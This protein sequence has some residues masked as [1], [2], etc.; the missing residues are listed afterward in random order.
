MKWLVVVVFGTLNYDFYVF[1][2]PKHDTK[3]ICMET[4]VDQQMRHNYIEKLLE[5]YGRP[6]PIE[7][8]NCL[9]EKKIIEIIKEYKKG[10]NKI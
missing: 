8:V 2:D 4:L 6:M 10:E 7:F 9:Q 1:T 5:E 3:E